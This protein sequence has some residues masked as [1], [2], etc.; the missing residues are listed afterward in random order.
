METFRDLVVWQKSMALAESIYVITK[1][2]PKEEQF[3]LISQI[4]RSAVSIPAN[5]A[6]GY[7]RQSLPDYIR[8]L[9]IS[10]G[11]LFELQTHIELSIRF[12]YLNEND[13]IDILN[14]TNEIGRMLNSLIKRLEAKK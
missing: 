10:R 8:F 9:K 3:G 12:S 14:N 5:I 6:E 7:G 4:R 13:F 11:S 2:F 1:Y